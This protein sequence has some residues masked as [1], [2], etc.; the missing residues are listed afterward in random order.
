MSLLYPIGNCNSSISRDIDPDGNFLNVTS[1]CN[2]YNEL[3]LNNLTDSKESDIK[4]SMLHLNAR[5]LRKNFD[6]FTQLLNSTGHEFSAI[7]ISETWLNDISEDYVNITG[8]RFI[9]SNRV[10]RLGRGRRSLFTR[11]SQF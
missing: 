7:G 9:S 3:D 2:Y 4:F 5:S 1:K 8:Y 11:H 6:K 10:G